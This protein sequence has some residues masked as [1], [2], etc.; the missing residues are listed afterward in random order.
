[1]TRIANPL[2]KCQ[3]LNIKLEE[4][5]GCFR[6]CTQQAVEGTHCVFMVVP[7]IEVIFTLQCLRLWQVGKYTMLLVSSSKDVLC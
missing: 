5:L 3:V 6:Q 4:S 1:M 7:F 2:C